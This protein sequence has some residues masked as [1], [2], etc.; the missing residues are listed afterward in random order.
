MRPAGSD[1]LEDAVPRNPGQDDEALPLAD[2]ESPAEG[3]C[4]AGTTIS[5]AFTYI[6]V[7]VR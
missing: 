6:S 2:L 7:R 5:A 3:V 1:N 4:I